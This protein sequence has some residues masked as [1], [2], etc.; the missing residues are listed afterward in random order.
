MTFILKCSCRFDATLMILL[1]V[2]LRDLQTEFLADP[3]SGVCLFQGLLNA[4]VR[5]CTCEN[6]TGNGMV[7]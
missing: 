6:R 3:A 7:K 4:I 1:P 5:I 2:I